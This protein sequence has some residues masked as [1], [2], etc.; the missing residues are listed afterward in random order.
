[1][2]DFVTFWLYAYGEAIN[3]FHNATFD[4]LAVDGLSR[5]NIS[6]A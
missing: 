1:M 3:L 6:A 4:L 2:N 5:E